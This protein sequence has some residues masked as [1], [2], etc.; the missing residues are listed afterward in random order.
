MFKK[1]I[2]KSVF[3]NLGLMLAL[4]ISLSAQTKRKPTKRKTVK[5]TA[6]AQTNPVSAATVEVKKNTRPEVETQ[7]GEQTGETA[8]TNARPANAAKENKSVYFYEFEQPKFTVSKI[9]IEHDENGK[10]KITFLKREF[11]ETVSD[12]V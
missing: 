2:T 8:K 4:T 1:K 12:P 7:P 9:Y 10:G 5:K 11:D 6:S 3:I